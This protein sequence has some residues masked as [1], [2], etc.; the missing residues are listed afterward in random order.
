MSRRSASGLPGQ[1]CLNRIDALSPS[2]RAERGAAD[3]LRRHPAEPGGLRRSRD[4]GRA[5]RAGFDDSAASHVASGEHRPR[6]VLHVPSASSSS[7]SRSRSFVARLRERSRRCSASACDFSQ[8]SSAC[9][10]LAASRLQPDSDV[11]LVLDEIE[12]APAQAQGLPTG[13][14]PSRGQQRDASAVGSGA[15][16]LHSRTSAASSTSSSTRPAPPTLWL[17]LS[18][19][20]EAR[21]RASACQRSRA[22]GRCR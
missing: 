8:E 20:V 11:Q 16:R 4:A 7:S 1:C 17:L 18:G 2:E 12:V 5:R 3:R 13:G 15:A 6:R 10:A 22:S 19:M 14:A 9:I 21:P